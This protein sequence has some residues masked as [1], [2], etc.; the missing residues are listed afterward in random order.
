LQLVHCLK[1]IK[2]FIIKFAYVYADHLIDKL[3]H[4]RYLS[5]VSSTL[6]AVNQKKR[7]VRTYLHLSPTQHTVTKV[8]MVHPKMRQTSAELQSSVLRQCN[9]AVAAL[10]TSGD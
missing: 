3:V 6:D 10:L 8:D 5:E 1:R 9:D 4:M 7:C 2:T